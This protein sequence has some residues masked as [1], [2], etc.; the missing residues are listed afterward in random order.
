MKSKIMITAMAISMI[1]YVSMYGMQSATDQEIDYAIEDTPTI[2]DRVSGKAMDIPTLN[3]ELFDVMSLATIDNTTKKEIIRYL[4]NRGANINAKKS[5]TPLISFA[6][7]NFKEFKLDADFIGF[8]IDNG[9]SLTIKDG[10]YRTPLAIA[11]ELN[12]LEVY[13]MLEFKRIMQK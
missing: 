1:S 10:L 7:E 9:A 6:I 4:L 11:Q 12:L 2:T 5:G 13:G 8:L 3:Q